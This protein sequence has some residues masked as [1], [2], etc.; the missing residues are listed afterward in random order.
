MLKRILALGFLLGLIAAFFA[1]CGSSSSSSTG[2]QNGTLVILAGD[3]PICNVLS[4]R[5]LVDGLTLTTASGTSSS[6]ISSNNAVPI[7]FAAL[8]DTSAILNTVS[9]TASTYTGGE[10]DVAAPAMSLFDAA[11]NPPI[12]VITPT[13]SSEKIN[14]TI[15]PPLVVRPCSS[16][17]T[18]PCQAAAVKLDFNLAQSIQSNGQGQVDVTG[19]PGS[20]TVAVNPV[21]NG[22][23]LAAPASGQPLAT[24]DDV[25]GYILSISS[26]PTSGSDFIGSFV[27]QTLPGIA[28]TGSLSGA[29]P[30][31]SVNLTSSSQL[32]GAP[33]LNQLTTGNFVE[34]E[35]HVDA[36]G[37]FVAD[38]AMIEDQTDLSQ[39]TT[40]FLGNILSVT[41]DANGNLTQ[42]QLY[43][44]DQ[45]PNTTAGTG[46]PV[47]LDTPPMVVN[48]SPSTGFHFS[49]PGANFPNL[50]PDNSYVAVGQ[51]VVV[52]ATYTPPPSVT[53]PA[54]APPTVATANNIYIP[55]QTVGG[56][57]A[58]LVSAGSD[59]VTGAF[60]LNPCSSIF[61]GRAIYVI[62]NAQTRF[63]NV[64]G[65]AGLTPA[66]QLQVR[67]LLFFDQNG[68]AISSIQVPPNSYVLLAQQVHLL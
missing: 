65:L 55:L 68:G 19:T 10:I 43:V 24:L 66:P 45:E 12:S 48:V 21:V 62:T 14:F 6:V 17:S 50:V 40:A 3:V 31:I 46:N 44:H 29:G 57:F 25:H 34:V 5:V 54:T 4:F 23:A 27:L 39:N 26:T 11:Q 30:A 47:P 15:T 33:A 16:T 32:I 53:A 49:S 63:L 41:K 13:F 64:N 20:L 1:G 28:V 2:T 37:N 51:E 36:Q 61:Q 52:H 22:T 18:T 60:Q 42:F 59:N 67:G 9:V 35:G 7:D 58:S 8:R 38:T 56:N